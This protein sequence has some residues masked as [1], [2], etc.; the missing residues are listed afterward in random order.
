MYF[1]IKA[2]ILSVH[3]AKDVGMDQRMIQ[4]RVKYSPLLV[5]STGDVDDTEGLIPGCAGLIAY[6]LEIPVRIL[7]RQIHPSVSNTDEREAD[8]HL[9]HVVM[10]GIKD[11]ISS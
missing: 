1:G 2:E 10:H 6:S 7:V 11:K 8:A 9:Y 4:S 5:R 3:I